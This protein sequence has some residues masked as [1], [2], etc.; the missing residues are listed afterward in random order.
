MHRGR[1]TKGHTVHFLSPG[2]IFIHADTRRMDFHRWARL[3]LLPPTRSW[4][5]ILVDGTS[6]REKVDGFA[7]GVRTRGFL[8]RK[9]LS[10]R[11]ESA[12]RVSGYRARRCE[13]KANGE[14]GVGRTEIR[15]SGSVIF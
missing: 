9:S 6:Y 15:C 8:S 14:L 13:R 3:D 5:A 11:P 12:L 10:R 4:G 2:S 1:G 7:G